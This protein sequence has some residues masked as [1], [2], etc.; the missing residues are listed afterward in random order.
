MTLTIL[1]SVTFPTTLAI[2]RVET[3]GKHPCRLLEIS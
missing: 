3:K 1:M 2:T